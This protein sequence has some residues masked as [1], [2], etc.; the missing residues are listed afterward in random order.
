[1]SAES[2]FTSKNLDLQHLGVRPLFYD[3]L[4]G[5]FV[6]PSDP[7]GHAHTLGRLAY[8]SVLKGE[9]SRNEVVPGIGRRVVDTYTYVPS[10]SG[11]ISRAIREQSSMGFIAGLELRPNVEGE[12]EKLGVYDIQLNDGHR[13]IQLVGTD[14]RTIP[15]ELGESIGQSRSAVTEAAQS[16]F[17]YVHEV[18]GGNLPQAITKEDFRNNWSTGYGHSWAKLVQKAQE[19]PELQLTVEEAEDGTVSLVGDLDAAIA[20]IEQTYRYNT[21]AYHA[22]LEKIRDERKFRKVRQ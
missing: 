8:A 4:S 3:A 11:V 12:V 22:I 21:P 2:G 15:L 1:M 10:W 16:F 14:E 7:N 6:P 17:D 20:W 19:N 5:E 9:I 13:G 18:S